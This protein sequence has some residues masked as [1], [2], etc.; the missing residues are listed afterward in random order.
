MHLYCLFL[1]KTY[2]QSWIKWRPSSVLT[3]RL[4]SEQLI[5]SEKPYYAA[6]KRVYYVMA[7]GVTERCHILF[8]PVVES[9]LHRS[10]IPATQEYRMVCPPNLKTWLRAYV[11]G[12]FVQWR[13]SQSLWQKILLCSVTVHSGRFSPVLLQSS[14]EDMWN[15]TQLH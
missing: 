5:T 8:N 3:L 11:N 12:R 4:S 10:E 9:M 6:I 2:H 7:I 15:P 13:L 14:N 1:P